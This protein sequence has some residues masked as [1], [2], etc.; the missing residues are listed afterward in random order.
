MIHGI[1]KRELI[2]ICVI[3]VARFFLCAGLLNDK[4]F[5][6]LVDILLDIYP[7]FAMIKKLLWKMVRER[8]LEKQKQLEERIKKENFF[9]TLIKGLGS[10]NKE[11]REMAKEQ[12]MSRA[13]DAADYLDDLIDLLH[14]YDA[15]VQKSVIW[16]LKKLT[17]CG[18]RVP[19]PVLLNLARTSCNDAIMQCL[20]L[21]T[22]DDEKQYVATEVMKMIS[23][24]SW[25]FCENVRMLAV[26][27]V[28]VHSKKGDKNIISECMSILASLSSNT[29]VRYCAFRVSFQVN[30]LLTSKDFERNN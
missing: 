26:S 4:D 20:L 14:S 21:L 16:V 23:Q 6:Q 12:F 27:L 15:E 3:N 30:N 11:L 28:L 18:V 5:S 1:E 17:K 29:K 19:I 22:P 24:N 2:P 13:S 8:P 7:S 25:G 9:K 10:S